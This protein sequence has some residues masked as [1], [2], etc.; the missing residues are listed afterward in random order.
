MS[1]F[2]FASTSFAAIFGLTAVVLFVFFLK[3][4][5]KSNVLLIEACL[6][7]VGLLTNLFVI[8]THAFTMPYAWRV[9]SDKVVTFAMP[10]IL[11]SSITVWIKMR[12][13]DKKRRQGRGSDTDQQSGLQ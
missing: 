1:T 8:L 4:S 9:L 2:Y 13:D 3:S 7:I 10:I 12:N 5:R 11:V 6:G